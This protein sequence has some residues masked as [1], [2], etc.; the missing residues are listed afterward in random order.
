MIPEIGHFFLITAFAVALLQGVLPLW[1]ASTGNAQLMAMGRT[2]AL[3]QL[4]LIALA[5]VCLVNAFLVNDFTVAYVASNSN[6]YLPDWFKISAVWGGHEGSLL[7]W[8]LILAG[9]GGAVA[10]L[11]KHLPEELLA[12]VLAVMGLLGVG[13]TS[14]ILFTSNP[15]LRLLPDFPLDGNDLNPLLQDIGLIIHPPMLYMGYVGFAVPFA[16]VIAGLIG[17]QLDSVWARWSRPWATVAWCFLTLGIALGSWWAYYELGWGGWWFWDPV[18]N[19]SFMPWLAGTALLHSLAVTDKRGGIKIWTA[20]LAILTFS[21]S[22][23]GTFL[24]RSG[25]LTSV[26]AFAADPERG[27]FILAFLVIVIGGSLLLFALR[28]HRLTSTIE[29]NLVSRESWLVFQNAIMSIAVVVV[30]LGTLYP[31]LSEA[32]GAGKLSVGPPYFNL[33]FQPLAYLALLLMA[34]APYIQ[35]RRYRFVPAH[36]NLFLLAG[37]SVALGVILPWF[38]F[39]Y[40]TWQVVLALSLSLWVFLST[41]KNLLGKTNFGKQGSG[42]ENGI[43]KVILSRSYLAMILAH[44]GFAV[45]II[46]IVLTSEYSLEKDVRM[47]PGDTLSAG[48]YQFEFKGVH[49]TRESNYRAIVGTIEV[50]Q[51]GK[52]VTQLKPEKRTYRV[53]QSSMT[54]AA[55]DAGFFRDLYVALGDSLGDGSWA[56]RVYYKPFV[57][58]IWMGSIFMALG[59]TLVLADRRY[60]RQ[61]RKSMVID[62]GKQQFSAD[63]VGRV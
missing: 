43:S 10:I 44:I 19:A 45:A 53:Q 7:L 20:L 51:N 48:S 58:W 56:V 25:V 42:T 50:T 16:F 11:G 1:G 40:V 9:W 4:M 3:T 47:Y 24:V 22:L 35:W 49:T 32:F 63:T 27:A 6:S 5:F 15:F 55:I 37:I 39:G 12:R 29:Y 2:T 23:L 17:G 57:R 36:R 14:F 46:G 21:L 60:R 31:L 13:F 61:Q 52:L 54:E 30:L 62:T 8:A 59:G 34:V 38:Y 41:L 18:E 26:H 28:A 33:L